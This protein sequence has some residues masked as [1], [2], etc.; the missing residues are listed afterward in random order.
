VAVVLRC[1]GA[2]TGARGMTQASAGAAK[3][4]AAVSLSC[5][6]AGASGNAGRNERAG[7]GVTSGQ[8]EGES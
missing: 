8:E 6:E 3:R 5:R 1:R 2:E 7:A 4:G